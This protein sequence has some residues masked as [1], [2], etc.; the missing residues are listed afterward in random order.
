VREIAA[1]YLLRIHVL[2]AN[3]NSVALGPATLI[4]C[5]TVAVVLLILV[6]E[7]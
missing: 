7:I 2:S 5:M 3:L 1:Q 6:L 4:F